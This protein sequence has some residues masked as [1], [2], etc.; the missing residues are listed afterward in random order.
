[1]CSK[2]KQKQKRLKNYLRRNWLISYEG[3][4]ILAFGKFHETFCGVKWRQMA[5]NDERLSGIFPLLLVFLN[6]WS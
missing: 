6:L 1:M 3:L 2:Q 4:K 5:S